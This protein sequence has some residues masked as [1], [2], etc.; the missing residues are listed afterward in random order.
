MESVLAESA[1]ME[2]YRTFPDNGRRIVRCNDP[3]RQ[4]YMAEHAVPEPQSACLA[5]YKYLALDE[6]FCYHGAV[7]S[8]PAPKNWS[9][10]LKFSCGFWL[11]ATTFA[12]AQDAAISPEEIRNLELSP[13]PW[14]LSALNIR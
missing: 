13:R 9:C 3:R 10:R 8:D 4:K 5:T 11:L 1:C 6:G 12:F 2:R 7:I 14:S